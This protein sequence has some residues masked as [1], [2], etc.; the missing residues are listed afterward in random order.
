M[1]L[2]RAASE[3]QQ[4]RLYVFDDHRTQVAPLAD[5]ATIL[6]TAWTRWA[7]E[8]PDELADRGR[9]LTVHDLAFERPS[10]EIPGDLALVQAADDSEVNSDYHV[11]RLVTFL[12]IPAGWAVMLGILGIGVAALAV[13][14]LMAV[15]RRAQWRR[16]YR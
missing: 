14:K 13:L 1:D 12:G 15:V 5:P 3:L 6:D 4:V 10:V 8:T 9:Y 2:S 11:T 16:I 7:G